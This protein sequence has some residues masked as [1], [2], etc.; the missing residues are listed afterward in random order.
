MKIRENTGKKQGISFL[1]KHQTLNVLLC[2]QYLI[3]FYNTSSA[4][5]ES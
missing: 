1:L 5:E 4:K 2:V 3:Y